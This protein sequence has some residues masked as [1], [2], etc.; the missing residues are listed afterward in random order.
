MH[1]L[2][3]GSDCHAQNIRAYNLN[4]KFEKATL[5]EILLHIEKQTGIFFC[6]SSSI[7]YDKAIISIALKNKSLPEVLDILCRPLGYEYIIYGNLCSIRKITDILY[8]RVK[9]KVVNELGEPLA[10]V[11]VIAENRLMCTDQ[12][13]SFTI[14]NIPLHTMLSFTSVGYKRME[15]RFDGKTDIVIHLSILPNNL[16]E[17]VVVSTGYQKLNKDNTPGSFMRI[18]NELLR[19]MTASDVRASL[20]GVV[21]GLLIT[22]AAGSAYSVQLRGQSTIGMVPGR[23]PPS[24]PMFIIDGIPFPVNNNTMQTV[25]PANGF[26]FQANSPLVTINPDDIEHIEILKDADAT[27]LY[28]SRGANGV[29][30][31]TT[32][33]GKPGKPLLEMKSWLGIGNVTRLPQ[34]MNTSQYLQMRREAFQNDNIAPNIKTAPDLLDWDTT[35]YTDF[36]KL[37]V[38]ETSIRHNVQA[39]ISGGGR[40]TQYFLSGGYYH[41]TSVFPGDMDFKRRSFH[42]HITHTSSNRKLS[43]DVVTILAGSENN[44]IIKDL[45]GYISLP[46]NMPPLLDSTGNLIWQEGGSS[47][48]NPMA[49]LRQPYSTQTFNGMLRGQLRYKVLPELYFTASFGYNQ[50]KNGDKGLLPILSQFPFSTTPLVGQYYVAK[51]LYS[52][53]ITE[54]Q[55]QYTRHIN[56]AE[57]TFL[58]GT[59]L[60]Q[61]FSHAS[62][63]LAKGFSNDSLLTNINA[64]P[65]V[66]YTETKSNYRYIGCFSRIGFQMKEKY[67]LNITLRRDG[68]TR[69][70]ESNRFGNFGAVGAGWLFGKESFL[71]KAFPFIS[72]GKLRTSFGITGDD[73]IVDNNNYDD[74]HRSYN[75]SPLDAGTTPIRITGA[76]YSWQK[77]HKL[78]L[79]LELGLLK[80]RVFL[81]VAA[82]R[83]RIGSQVVSY[84]DPS[85]GLDAAMAR[86]SPAIVQ[87]KGL[88]ILLQFKNN[89]VG[90]WHW[91]SNLALTLPNNKL[92]AFPG[93]SSSPYANTLV[94]G[95]SLSV[96]QGYKYTGVNPVTGLFEVADLNGDGTISR[97]GDYTIIG[98]LDP[99]LYG[100][101]TLGLSY[102]NWDVDIMLEGRIQ[103]GYSLPYQVYSQATPGV[104]MVNLPVYFQNRW[105]SPGDH[106]NFQ[107]LSAKGD[108]DSRNAINNFLESEARLTPASYMRLRNFYLSYNLP[109]NN[110]FNGFFTTLRCY[111]TAGNLFTITKYKG[112]DPETQDAFTRPP[113]KTFTAG[114]QFSL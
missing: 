76:Q 93:L 79:A 90:Q 68:S 42:A 87:N 112:A 57:L 14:E 108:P 51:N 84:A 4:I 91:Y 94:V 49:F 81:S 92:L 59:T 53:L 107:R 104:D 89:K 100:S 75:R 113:L 48:A 12:S 56:K 19:R 6:T 72:Y 36:K 60:Q 32:K 25:A 5:S 83:N 73:Q 102:K 11:T 88:E 61:T 114:L 101:L 63:T 46:P 17:A 98:D 70:S 10:G 43:V 85:Q 58:L 20:E 28:G 27:A 80:D 13:G 54:P 82:Y 77:N 103:K 29:I 45:T 86:N 74:W 110:I 35:R 26:G 52:S 44:S 24:D 38:G 97:K 34:M 33:K 96:Q 47:F 105:R 64:A 1:F 22:Q 50:M 69:L 106:S 30:L 15:F 8:R 18:D 3:T 95:R 111:F 23:L 9:G 16:L 2:I 40:N 37:L 31:I 55:L 66:V 62:N 67:L 7:D 65:D 99:R 41:E 78:E 21:P 109:V 39:A 71:K